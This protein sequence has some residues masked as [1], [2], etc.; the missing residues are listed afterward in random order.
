VFSRFHVLSNNGIKAISFE[1]LKVISYDV[2]PD[3]HFYGH[4]VTNEEVELQTLIKLFFLFPLI[5]AEFYI[6]LPL[7]CFVSTVL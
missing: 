1:L 6:F 3:V 7:F 5:I 4:I 2:E